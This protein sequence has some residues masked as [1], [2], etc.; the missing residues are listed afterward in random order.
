MQTY[1]LIGY[2]LS[3]S[4]S[5]DYFTKKFCAENINAKYLNFPINEISKIEEVVKNNPLLCGLNVTI[6]YKEKIIPFLDEIDKEA[7]EIGA[8]N[9]IKIIKKSNKKPY[10]VGYNSD[11]TGFKKSLEPLIKY[12]HS[13]ALILG[14]GGAS[15]AVA[16][17]LKKMDIEFKFVS[18]NSKNK[19]VLT[20]NQLT[21]EII[22]SYKLIINT[23]PLGM[24]PNIDQTPDIPYE[25]VSNKH[26]LYDL[27]Y[28]PKQTLFMKKGAERGA[29]T[30]NGLKMLQL[31]A[32]QGWLIWNNKA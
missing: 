29:K 5:K 17:S 23:S 4:F 31:Q 3:H 10:L 13:K 19:E 25:G 8:V 16:Y 27:I 2:P 1:G 6:P 20:Y 21:P 15:K 28:N 11:I 30:E 9:V 7:E 22:S 14:T 12:P 24:Y 18:R 26:L 32:E